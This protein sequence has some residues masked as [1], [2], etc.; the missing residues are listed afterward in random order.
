[1]KRITSIQ[2][3]NFRAFY[4]Q[5][6]PIVLLTGENLLLYGENGSGKSSLFK[7]LKHYFQSSRQTGFVFEEN[8][9]APAPVNGSIVISFSDVDA[10]GLPI[11]GT[12]QILTFSNT[13]SNHNV[14]LVQ[15]TDLIKGFFDYRSLL[16]VYFGSQNNLFDLVVNEILYEHIPVG[17]TE[18]IGFQLKS[19]RQTLKTTDR[20]FNDHWDALY[21]LPIYETMFRAL[22]DRVFLRLNRFLIDYFKFNLRVWYELQPIEFDHDFKVWDIKQDLRLIIKLNGRVLLNH[23]EYLNEARLS[24]LAICLYLASLKQNPAAFDYKILFLDDVFIGLDASNRIPILK[25]LKQEFTDYQ[26]L[27]T[28]YDRHWYELAQRFFIKNSPGKWVFANLYVGKQ[29]LNN[30]IFDTPILIQGDNDSSKAIYYL[31]HPDKPDY[32]AAANYFRKYSEEILT[33]H[34]PPQEIRNDD[35][36]LIESYKLTSLVS[37]GL[38]FL[39]KIGADNSLLTQLD[40]ALPTLLHPLSHF[41]LAS[42]VYKAELIDVENCLLKLEPYLIALKDNYRV[43][44]PQGRMFKLNFTI[45]ATDTSYYEIYTKETIYLIRNAGAVT[46]SSGVCHSKT[47]YSV[48][49]GVR[50]HGKN[51]NNSDP[52]ASYTSIE[53]AYDSIYGYL[54]TQ[55]ASVHIV[56]AAQ[57]STEFL[58]HNGT[59]WQ[60]LN[61]LIIW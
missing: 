19:I 35:L 9:Y 30:I 4:G 10:A 32:P 5:Y 44:L 50:M 24:A 6:D 25:I 31:H 36:S 28:S 37:S 22:L 39:N 43:L 23:T 12:Q 40:I 3:Q 51:F 27:I 55:L 46:L 1:M 58:I 60:P 49:A 34:L 7:A 15:N 61:T 52:A 54:I 18:G 48:S 20:R 56:R 16:K 8:S 17:E 26:I 29:Q 45:N 47:C 38:H 14:A 53:N 33:D 13:V 57:Y 41:N 2:L 42:P 11:T 21:E 59:N